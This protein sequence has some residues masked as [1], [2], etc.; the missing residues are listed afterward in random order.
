MPG[1]PSPDTAQL[2][3]AGGGLGSAEALST[4]GDAARPTEERGGGGAGVE[5]KAHG[6]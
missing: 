1:L 4:G 2:E 5:S 6:V 3:R